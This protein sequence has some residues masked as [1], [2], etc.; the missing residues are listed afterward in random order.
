MTTTG[1][2]VVLD[3]GVR[4]DHDRPPAARCA[5]L[6]GRVEELAA[7]RHRCP[8]RK[9]NRWRTGVQKSGQIAVDV[10]TLEQWARWKADQIRVRGPVRLRCGKPLGKQSENEIG[11]VNPFVEHTVDVGQPELCPKRI[12]PG[13][14]NRIEDPAIDR[15]HEER[16]EG[17][18]DRRGGAEV[19]CG[20]PGEARHDVD[21][22]RRVHPRQRE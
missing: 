13:R 16:A 14:G 5:R 3:D 10:G 15:R 8:R 9:D 12:Q 6:D 2:A 20:R 17:S 11:R 1:T 7:E 21:E 4:R 18:D 19:A 22:I